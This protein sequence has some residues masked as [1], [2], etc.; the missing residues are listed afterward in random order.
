[1][2]LSSSVKNQLEIS[3]GVVAILYIGGNL[4]YVELIGKRC[5]KPDK[6]HC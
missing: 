2:H 6:N 1:M 3:S 5:Q 4:D